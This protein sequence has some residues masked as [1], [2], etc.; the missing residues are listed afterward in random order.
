LLQTTA[1][2][3]IG[4]T[5]VAYAGLVVA[6]NAFAHGLL[7]VAGA[8]AELIG[9]KLAV[10]SVEEAEM[11]GMEVFARIEATAADHA[12]TLAAEALVAGGLGVALMLF[13]IGVTRGRPLARRGVQVLLAGRVVQAAVLA[14]LLGWSLGP[15]GVDVVTEFRDLAERYGEAW[16]PELDAITGSLGPVR[17][18][19][20]LFGVVSAGPAVLLLWLTSIPACAAWCSPSRDR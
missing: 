8:A 18:V 4:L 16:P 17:T 19:A 5:V 13:G 6:L 11:V 3:W 12:G 7:R 2:A 14:W 10:E 15:E 1:G 9:L 20:V